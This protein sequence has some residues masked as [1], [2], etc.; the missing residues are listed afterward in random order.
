VPKLSGILSVCALH[1]RF[2][3]QGSPAPFVSQAGS[4]LRVLG[5]SGISFFRMSE[6]SARWH[7]WVIN[8]ILGVQ[9]GNRDVDVT[10]F[11]TT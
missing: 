1:A 4:L 10:G 6:R 5:T 9:S 7:V 11:R 2:D 3:S 8:Q